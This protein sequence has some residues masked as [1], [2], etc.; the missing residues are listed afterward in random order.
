MFAASTAVDV[1]EAVGDE[2]AG[3]APQSLERQRRT[4]PVAAEPFATHVVAGFDPHT[5]VQTKC[6]VKAKEEPMT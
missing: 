5:G 2:I 1:L 6:V 4:R 3:Q